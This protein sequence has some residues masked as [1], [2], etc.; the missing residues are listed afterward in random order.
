MKIPKLMIYWGRGPKR[1]MDL[2]EMNFGAR[3]LEKVRWTCK[4]KD[5]TT[6]TGHIVHS[7]QN[8][9]LY[10]SSSGHTA[11][12]VQLMG[13]VTSSARARTDNHGSPLLPS[14][15]CSRRS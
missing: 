14:F 7:P 15:P 6:N 3:N 12:F 11:G 8:P 13:K 1:A 4:E 9:C 2:Y 10:P 5:L